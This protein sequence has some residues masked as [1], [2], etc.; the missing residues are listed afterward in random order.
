MERGVTRRRAMEHVLRQHNR[1]SVSE[2]DIR[3]LGPAANEAFCGRGKVRDAVT[4]RR[5]GSRAESERGQSAGRDFMDWAR[6]QEGQSQRARGP[7]TGWQL[8]GQ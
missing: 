8:D 1:T 5:S 4:T 7:K 3:R 2:A 6:R